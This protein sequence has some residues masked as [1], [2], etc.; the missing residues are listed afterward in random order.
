MAPRP[1]QFIGHNVCLSPAFIIFSKLTP[2]PIQFIIHNVCVPPPLLIN[3]V[4][5]RLF[6]IENWQ[7]NNFSFWPTD[8]YVIFFFITKPASAASWVLSSV[9]HCRILCYPIDFHNR[10]LYAV[11]TCCMTHDTWHATGGMCHMGK[12]GSFLHRRT[13]ATLCKWREGMPFSTKNTWHVTCNMLHVT[14]C[15]GW[16]FSQNCSSLALL[17]C[18]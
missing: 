6:A 9:F 10:I 18:D 4:K 17:V 14:C 5:C 13:S 3:W 11:D 16:T 1:K 2:R 8:V 7:K 15:G 12:V